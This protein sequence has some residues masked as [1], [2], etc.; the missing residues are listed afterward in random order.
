[1]GKKILLSTI[2]TLYIFLA[3]LIPVYAAGAS[4]NSS[5]STSKVVV[6]NT[7]TF[8][9]KVNSSQASYS[10]AYSVS[11]DSSKLS[12]VGGSGTSNGAMILSG[13]KSKTITLRFKAKSSGNPKV[14]ISGQICASSCYNFSGSKSVKVISQAE[15]EAS[16]SSNNYL[17]SL[18]VEGAKLSPSFSKTV[19]SYTFK[20][21]R[22]E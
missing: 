4:V 5:T 16:K 14:K 11:Y 9:F 8:T 19:T 2:M 21:Y 22:Y 3:S 20:F 10:M 15:Y 18:S 7:V 13:E 12:Y 6:G 17:S 1:M